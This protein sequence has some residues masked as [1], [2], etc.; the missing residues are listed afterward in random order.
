MTTCMNLNRRIM[1]TIQILS[2]GKTCTIM[3]TCTI[4][5]KVYKHVNP[6]FLMVEIDLKAGLQS[7]RKSL[8]QMKALLAWE[9][10]KQSE[11]RPDRAPGFTLLEH[12]IKT[13]LKN[14]YSFFLSTFLQMRSILNNGTVPIDEA[15]RSSIE[16]EMVKI[17]EQTYGL[18]LY[19][20]FC[21]YWKK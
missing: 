8:K 6:H 7:L 20:R 9:Q 11:A 17:E 5:R 16:K 3:M 13:E 14:E 1:T 18:N 21:E 10:L 19:Q 2:V 15:D 12:S 4:D